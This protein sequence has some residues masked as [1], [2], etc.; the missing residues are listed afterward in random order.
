MAKQLTI[1]RSTQIIKKLTLRPNKKLSN[2]E[3]NIPNATGNKAPPRLNA[4]YSPF[5]RLLLKKGLNHRRTIPPPSKK[6]HRML[7][8]LFHSL[9]RNSQ[10]VIKTSIALFMD[11][12]ELFL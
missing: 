2:K 7:R 5:V 8:M 6:M 11:K 9:F 10:L 12:Q 1:K 4:K 3:T